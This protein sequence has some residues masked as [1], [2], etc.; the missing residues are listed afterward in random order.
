MI[1]RAVVS[2]ILVLALGAAGAA[3]QKPA[4]PKPAAPERVTIQELSHW[5]GPVTFAHGD[6]A[7]L[8]GDCMSCH[9]HAEGEVGTC[10]TCHPKSF[11]P[12]EPTMPSLNVALHERCVGCHRQS[13][14]GPVSCEDC[15]KRKELPPGPHLPPAK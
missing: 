7:S 15:H 12:S 5:F 11:D 4:A 9:H 14:S 10:G 13:G 2:S 1:K 3:T 6:H 8:A